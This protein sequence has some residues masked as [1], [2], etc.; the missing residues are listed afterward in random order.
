ME[1]LRRARRHSPSGPAGTGPGVSEALPAEA[2]VE[3]RVLVVNVDPVIESAG[4][5]RLNALLGFND[6]YQLAQGYCRDLAE[7]S[8]GTVRYGIGDWLDVD[9]HPLKLDGFRYTDA[10]F[11]AAWHG[12]GQPGAPRFH[13]PDAVDYHALIRD[14][15]LVERIEVGGVDEVWCFAYPYAGLWESTLAGPG[16]Y[17]C[18]SPPVEGVPTSRLFAIMGFNPE[19]GVGEMLENFGHRTESI[20]RHVYGSW[21]PAHPQHAWDRFTRYD[22]VAPGQAACG[23][24]HFAPNSLTDYDWGNR[25]PVLSSA[26]DWLN[27][28][29]L[30]GRHRPMTAADWGHGDIRAHHRWWLTRLPQAP[31]RGPDG[32]LANWWRYV[33]D[34]NRYP[35][36]AGLTV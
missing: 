22:R 13:E 24:I 31:G 28:P 27:Y 29:D 3:P 16:A 34:F 9:Y 2:P 35:E 30:T 18:N 32:R 10:T 17:F 21:N 23:N 1:W 5:R 36:S 19:R 33:V 11:L 4:G 8:G 20:M 26:D 12:R 14:F 6:P 7:C 15:S 25:R